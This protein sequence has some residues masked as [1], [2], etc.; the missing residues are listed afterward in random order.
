MSHKIKSHLE[1]G[2]ELDAELVLAA[3]DVSL[4]PPPP[5]A[6]APNRTA[7]AEAGSA[8]PTL[9]GDPN[10][11]KPRMRDAAFGCTNA[12]LSG[13]IPSGDISTCPCEDTRVVS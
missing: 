9:T 2:A 1:S 3:G 8:D 7:S 13:V 6:V 10:K 4:P 5:A 11:D 12:L